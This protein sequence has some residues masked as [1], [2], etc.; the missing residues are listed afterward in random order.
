MFILIFGNGYVM[1]EILTEKERRRYLSRFLCLLYGSTD[2]NIRLHAPRIGIF[3]LMNIGEYPGKEDTVAREL[4]D[5]LIRKGLIVEGD[6]KGEIRLTDKGVVESR[7]ID[8]SERNRLEDWDNYQ[9]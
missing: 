6:S 7:R 2:G 3:N 5:E 1:A 4:A 8:C 9:L